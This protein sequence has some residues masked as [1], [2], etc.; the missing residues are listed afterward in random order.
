MQNRTFAF[1]IAVATFSIQHSAFSMAAATAAAADPVDLKP[2][3]LEC[4][5]VRGAAVLNS[6]TVVAVIGA[7]CLGTR[8]RAS[9]WRITSEEDPA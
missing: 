5:G 4:Y 6:N 8:D 2:L 1:W 9:A 7:S 3:A